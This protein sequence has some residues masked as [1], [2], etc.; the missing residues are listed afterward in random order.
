MAGLPVS[1][2]LSLKSGD[3]VAFRV[4]FG[5]FAEG[6]DPGAGTGCSAAADEE[7]LESIAGFAQLDRG[8]GMEDDAIGGRLVKTQV[9]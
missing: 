6:G 1:G 7:D 3:R 4:E 2:L 5:E 8:G 9:N